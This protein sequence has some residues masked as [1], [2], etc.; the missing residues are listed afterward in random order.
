MAPQLTR[1]LA[2]LLSFWWIVRIWGGCRRSGAPITDR[3]AVSARRRSDS[4]V[5]ALNLHNRSCEELFSGLG[6]VANSRAKDL[7]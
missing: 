2:D 7:H 1:H 5:G 3:E 4:G 6:V